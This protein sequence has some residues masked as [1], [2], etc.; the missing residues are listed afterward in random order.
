[1]DSLHTEA[2]LEL[3]EEVHLKHLT[4]VWV[5]TDTSDHFDD[6]DFRCMQQRLC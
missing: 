4:M 2:L 3:L 6:P 5:D 1:M